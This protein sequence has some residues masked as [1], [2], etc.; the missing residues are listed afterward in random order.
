MLD[1]LDF[2]DNKITIEHQLASQ[3][4]IFSHG[5]GVGRDGRGLLS[6]IAHALPSGYGFVLFDYNDIDEGK[7][8]VRF[9]SFSKQVERL[10]AVI[11]W[12]R[13]QPGVT[14]LHIVGHS[15]GCIVAADLAPEVIGTV[16][17]LAPPTKFN[18]SRQPR[19]TTKPGAK[20]VEGIWHIPRKDGTTTIIA[21]ADF[22]ELARI[23]PEGELVKLALFRA[24]TLV[25]AEADEVLQDDDYTELIVMPNVTALGIE[26][27]DHNFSG[28]ARQKVIETVNQQ[29][30]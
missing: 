26:G 4:V 19:M 24:Y 21:Q 27:A 15:V 18:E 29:L 28:P 25:I 3:M 9:T 17:L 14:T 2:A 11:D 10:K 5:F 7:H 16:V 13:R 1:T 12:T 8:T 22:D 23:D 6:D 30:A 20:Q